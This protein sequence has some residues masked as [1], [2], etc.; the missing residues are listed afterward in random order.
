MNLLL[1]INL[2]CFNSEKYLRETLESVVNQTYKDWELVIINDGSSDSTE[3]IILEY[4]DKGYP[5]VYHSQENKGLGFSRNKALELSRGEF[6]AFL[7]HDDMWL[8][9]K[10]E[11][12][13][14]AFLNNRD[15]DFAYTNFYVLENG[16]KKV[17]FSKRQPDGHVF[18]RFL[19]HYPVAVL[20]VMVRRE[21][22]NGLGGFF[23][24]R[25]HLAEEYDLFMRLLCKSKA[26]YVD[27]PLAVYRVHPDMSS[28][29]FFEKWPEEMA[30]IMD[31]LKRMDN[32]LEEKY[33]AGFRYLNAKIGYYRA[34]SEMAKSNRISARQYLNPFKWTDNKFLL[35]YLMTYL[36]P[37][38]WRK[39][40]AHRDGGT[41]CEPV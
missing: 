5:I 6:V 12:Q 8:P 28:I 24:R 16:D 39:V 19:H 4:I 13:V 32:T 17:S 20:T 41:F 21:A 31:K 2:C 7:D 36:H 3:A 22:L 23:D 1:S 34:R 29:K 26:V 14:S 10:A 30:Y 9:E 40:H 35:L 25:L 27:T 18:E 33:S 11:R 15:A 38:V 37:W